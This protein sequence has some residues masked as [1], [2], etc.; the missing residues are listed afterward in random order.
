[1]DDTTRGVGRPGAGDEFSGRA[2]ETARNYA[3]EPSRTPRTI[4]P[5]AAEPT[6]TTGSTGSGDLDAESDRR[7]REIQGEIASTRAEMSET[8]DALQEKLRP[9]NIVSDATERVKTATSERVR[10]MADRASGTAQGVMQEARHNAIPALMIGAGVAWMLIDRSRHQRDR[11]YEHAEWSEYSSPRYGAYGTN[12]GTNEEYYEASGRYGE[13]EY[14]QGRSWTGQR[15]TEGMSRWARNAGSE[16]R[17]TARRAQNGLQRMMNDNPLLVGAAAMLVGAAIGASLPETE[18]E[19]EWMGET[20]DSIIDRAQETA[21][22][23][24]GAVKEATSDVVGD[25]VNKVAEKVTGS[26]KK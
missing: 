16:A 7:T 4:P 11:H 25:T 19:N 6:R 15:S 2:D 26:E 22:R 3:G 1:M 10:G 8:I 14:G 21:E 9:S 24:V 5:R 13:G 23:T 17:H 18:K 20:R 12:Y